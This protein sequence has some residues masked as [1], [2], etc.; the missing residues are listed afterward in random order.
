[1]RA[2]ALLAVL[3]SPYFLCRS[4]T[5]PNLTVTLHDRDHQAGSVTETPLAP[6]PDRSACAD[7]AHRRA[8]Q[9]VFVGSDNGAALSTDGKIVVRLNPERLVAEPA[10]PPPPAGALAVIGVDSD[11]AL[12]D[13]YVV[14]SAHLDG[15]GIGEPWGAD[16]I[17]NGAFDD[18]AYVAT[19]IDFAE[20]L[21]ET[22][23]RLRRS[24]LFAV[25]TGE[26]KGL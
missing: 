24:L 17:Y 23:T 5:P 16:R 2:A 8:G 14:V 1:M 6:T 10:I 26:E 15:Y 13:E 12:A 11:P 7:L 4:E 19:L 22:G 18:A 9:L 3:S 20:R 25:V 21:R